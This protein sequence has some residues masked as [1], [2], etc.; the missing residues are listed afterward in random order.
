MPETSANLD[1]EAF[2]GKHDVW[3]PR[4]IVATD[5]EAKSH[6]AQRGPKADLGLRVASSDR[7]HVPRPL[8]G[9]DSVRH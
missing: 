7:S 5:P 3:P 4:E 6:P 2:S 8:R 9:L 1:G